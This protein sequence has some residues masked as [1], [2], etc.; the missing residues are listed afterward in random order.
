M[1]EFAFH[2]DGVEAL[3]HG[4]QPADESKKSPRDLVAE[5]AQRRSWPEVARDNGIS[6]ATLMRRLRAVERTARELG[7]KLR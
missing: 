4:L 7:E 6:L 5:V 3:A 1:F 2:R